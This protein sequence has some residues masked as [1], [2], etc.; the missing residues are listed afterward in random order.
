MKRSFV[1]LAPSNNL[2]GESQ[3]GR[4]Q[5]QLFARPLLQKSSGESPVPLTKAISRSGSFLSLLPPLLTHSSLFSLTLFYYLFCSPWF[6]AS[7]SG[8]YGAFPPSV[9]A[10]VYGDSAPLDGC[11]HSLL[12]PQVLPRDIL[13]ENPPDKY[14]NFIAVRYPVEG[15]KICSSRDDDDKLLLCGDCGRQEVHTFCLS[16]PLR[17]SPKG[18]WSCWACKRS[19][20]RKRSIM[21]MGDTDDDIMVRRASKRERKVSSK[22]ASYMMRQGAT[23]GDSNSP[24][25]SNTDQNENEEFRGTPYEL[26][27]PP[28]PEGIR[29]DK[30]KYGTFVWVNPGNSCFDT[31]DEPPYPKNYYSV[32]R[33]PK[34][35]G[36]DPSSFVHLLRHPQIPNPSMVPWDAPLS[37]PGEILNPTSPLIPI[38]IKRVYDS[39]FPLKNLKK[40]NAAADE[41]YIIRLLGPVLGE[42]SGADH[43]FKFTNFIVM[44]RPDQIWSWEDGIA[45]GCAKIGL[46][47]SGKI[48]EGWGWDR[49]VFEDALTEAGFFGNGKGC[50]RKRKKKASL[51]EDEE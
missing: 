29:I 13:L 37:W 7:T 49:M 21:L 24:S 8:R 28:P 4:T 43:P 42:L 50:K 25:N 18:G 16:P 6:M 19:T 41:R 14:E 20:K 31:H 9:H 1:S 17:K 46:R 47:M 36:I 32:T 33:P 44:R 12:A 45:A 40:R 35:S 27:P 34:V 5:D 39:K 38:H 10:L 2:I 11:V 26:L 23:N 48:F 30:S 15:C 3:N 22:A 51:T